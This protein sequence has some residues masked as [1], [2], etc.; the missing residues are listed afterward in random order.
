MYTHA[1]NKFYRIQF[2]HVIAASNINI[3]PLSPSYQT[4]FNS[5]SKG[6]S[7]AGD[8]G[9]SNRQAL[10]LLYGWWPSPTDRHTEPEFQSHQKSAQSLACVI[11]CVWRVSSCPHLAWNYFILARNI[12]Q[13]PPPIKGVWSKAL[14]AVTPTPPS[15]TSLD[16]SVQ[17]WR[18]HVVQEGST[19]NHHD[20]GVDDG[21][22]W[23]S[24]A[25]LSGLRGAQLLNLA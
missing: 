17:K 18:W 2:E 11:V 19:M 1:T 16:R 24:W 3:P 8:G 15:V 23:L 25:E 6:N 13:D 21:R 9:A 12:I 10:P 4:Q 20:D 14:A 5:S 22:G 7:T